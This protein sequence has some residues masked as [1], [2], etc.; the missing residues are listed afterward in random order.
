MDYIR[1]HLWNTHMLSPTEWFHYMKPIVLQV[2]K[3][4]LTLSICLKTIRFVESNWIQTE[5]TNQNV[6][7]VCLPK[8]QDFLLLK[9][10]HLP[11]SKISATLSIWMFGDQHLSAHLIIA[12]M[13]SPKSMKLL[14][15]WRSH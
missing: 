2:T 8:L 6:V 4:M 1:S 13:H 12:S 15:G 5:W 14:F 9:Y 10:D 3:T 11:V 7:P